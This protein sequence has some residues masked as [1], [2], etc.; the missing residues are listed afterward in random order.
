MKGKTVLITGCNRGIGKEAVRLLATRGANIICCIR[1][2]NPEFSK[3]TAYLENEFDIMIEILYFDMTDEA[4]IKNAIQP[5]MKA[6]RRIDVLINN[7]GIA[8]GA[9]FQ[10]TSIAKIKDVFQ[11]NFFSH[12]LI[13]QMISKLMMLHKSGSIINL[14][15]VAGLDNFGGYTAYGSSKAAIMAFTRIIAKELAS[16]NVRVNAIAPGLTDT[17]MA[18]QMEDKAWHEMVGRTDMQR[19]GRPEEIANLIVYL[20]SDESSFITGQTIR[21]DGGM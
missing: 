11:M 21:I 18:G 16:Y 10:M 4:G 3:F 2:E 19:L 14:G 12:V 7:A 20:A 6:K 8:T 9:L 13:T 15:S 5:L 17:G 1:K